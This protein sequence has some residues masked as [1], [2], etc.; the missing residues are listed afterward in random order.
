MDEQIIKE[1]DS[2]QTSLNKKIKSQVFLLA[3]DYYFLIKE[4]WFNNISRLINY[5][6]NNHSEIRKDNNIILEMKKEQPEFID[7]ISFMLDCLR[8]KIY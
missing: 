5:I 2:F 8:N 6:K 4:N 1:F 7:D 3:N